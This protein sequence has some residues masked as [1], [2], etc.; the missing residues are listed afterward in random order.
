MDSNTFS[1]NPHSEEA[2]KIFEASH[3]DTYK[4]V[5]T[6]RTCPFPDLY[7]FVA[8]HPTEDSNRISFTEECQASQMISD[9][10]A[11]KAIV[12][13]STWD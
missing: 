8:N 6:K 9:K 11:S 1:F 3:E 13:S 5:G 7:K 4:L 12:N 2:S 10:A